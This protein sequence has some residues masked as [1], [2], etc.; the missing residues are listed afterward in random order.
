MHNHVCHQAKN[1]TL[2]FLKVYV[3][4]VTA[5][6]THSLIDRCKL[7]KQPSQANNLHQILL[8]TPLSSYFFSLTGLLSTSLK[9]Y[10]QK[11]EGFT[12]SKLILFHFYNAWQQRPMSIYQRSSKHRLCTDHKYVFIFELTGFL[13]YLISNQVTG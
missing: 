8:S 4:V 2:I 12:Y 5:S 3:Q 11:P 9:Y 10:Q 6:V 7:L 13:K 1:H